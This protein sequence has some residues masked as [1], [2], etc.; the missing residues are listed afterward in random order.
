MIFQKDV[1]N[2]RQTLLDGR[3]LGNN[4]NTIGASINHFLKTTNLSFS[5]FKP[6]NELIFILIFHNQYPIPLGGIGQLG[7]TLKPPPGLEPGTYGLRY[8]RSTN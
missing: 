5:N 2:I 4:I 1:L 8:R 7:I 6:T 3:G